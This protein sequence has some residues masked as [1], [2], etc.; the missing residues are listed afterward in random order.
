MELP[1]LHAL[2]LFSLAL[3]TLGLLAVMNITTVSF[4]VGPFSRRAYSLL[5]FQAREWEQ[6]DI[7]L[8]V[9]LCLLK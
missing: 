7:F 5:V 2:L 3:G 4:G 9:E 1:T 8:P 6:G